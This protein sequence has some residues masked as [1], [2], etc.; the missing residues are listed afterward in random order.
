MLSNIYDKVFAKFE[1]IL[2]TWFQK[3]LF[4]TF[5]QM[6]LRFTTYCSRKCF[7]DSIFFHNTESACFLTQ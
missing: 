4:S 2:A 7:Y 6:Y 3:I 1:Q 5:L